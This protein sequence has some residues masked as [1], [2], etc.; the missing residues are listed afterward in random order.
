MIYELQIAMNVISL[1]LSF[2]ITILVYQTYKKNKAYIEKIALILE[3]IFFSSIFL[4]LMNLL[5][6]ISMI[7]AILLII[8]TIGFFLM[9][10]EFF[11]LLSGSGEIR[12]RKERILVYGY[13]GILNIVLL[14]LFLLNIQI[15][16][17]P[18]EG[19]NYFGLPYLIFIGPLILVLFPELYIAAITFKK[20]LKLYE[21]PIQ[22]TLIT[23]FIILFSYVLAQY[24]VFFVIEARFFAYFLL[25]AASIASIIF[26]KKDPNFLVRTGT[27]FAFKTIFLI[28]N[29]GQT[30]YSQE[31]APILSE[32]TDKKTISYLIG[33]FI[34]AITH[35]IKE[36]MKQDYGSALRSMD[37]GTLKMLFYYNS[38]IFGVLF[39][40]TVNN[41]MYNKLRN[42]VNA[43]EQAFPE[44]VSD[45]DCTMLIEDQIQD[46]KDRETLNKIKD[47][48]KLHFKF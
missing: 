28:K 2:F 48:L 34:Y 10:H 46:E 38:H 3:V 1:I 18:I 19:H 29:N 43:F 5:I 24:L 6:P 36:I 20:F 47:L 26:L 4:F 12:P 7:Y 45:Q 17:D 35:G 11:V 8:I 30:I 37:F 23:F 21:K 22:Y 32:M 44:L 39:S 42:F 27:S 13:M 31:F 9:F 16:T 33:G 15:E 41:L 40:T 14:V 25:I